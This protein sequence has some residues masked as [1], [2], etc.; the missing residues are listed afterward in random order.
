MDNVQLTNVDREKD[1]GVIVSTDLKPNNQCT[2]LVKTRNKLE[3]LSPSNQKKS[4]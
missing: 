2:D 4:Y 1:L 3:D